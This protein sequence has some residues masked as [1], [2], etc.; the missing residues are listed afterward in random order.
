MS[1]RTVGKTRSSTPTPSLKTLGSSVPRSAVPIGTPSRPKTTNGHTSPGRMACQTAGSVRVCAITEQIT[2]SDEAILGRDCRRARSR[3]PRVRFR[4]P[5]GRRR[6]RRQRRRTPRLPPHSSPRFLSGRDQSTRVELAAVEHRP[7]RLAG[8]RAALRLQATSNCV[9]LRLA[10]AIA[11]CKPAVGSTPTATGRVAPG[12]SDHN[13]RS[14]F[15]AT[16]TAPTGRMNTV[17]SGR[18]CARTSRPARSAAPV[19]RPSSAAAPWLRHHEGQRDRRSR[20]EHR[21]QPPQRHAAPQPRQRA[22]RRRA[23]RVLDPTP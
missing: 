21:G 10:V 22:G 4:T 3:A 20:G 2:T 7:G 17:P 9:P 13:S 19:P 5:P 16:D 11:A 18:T 14:R 8:R 1:D 12:G 15:A 6:T 23:E